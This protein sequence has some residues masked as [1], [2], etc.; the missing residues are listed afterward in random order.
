MDDKVMVTAYKNTSN[1]GT[2]TK[3]VRQQGVKRNQ[4]RDR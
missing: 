2:K 1:D 4:R 3:P